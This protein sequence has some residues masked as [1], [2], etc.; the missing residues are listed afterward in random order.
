[1]NSTKSGTIRISAIE[2]SLPESCVNIESYRPRFENFDL[3]VSR[4][5]VTQKHVAGE[6]ETALDLAVNA[7]E[8]LEAREPGTLASLDGIIFITQTPDYLFPGNSNLLMKRLGIEQNILNYDLNQGCAGFVYGAN[9]AQSMIATNQASTVALIC[10]DTYSKII[11][12]DD[13]GTSLLFGDGCAVTIFSEEKGAFKLNGLAVRQLARYADLFMVADG[14]A[15]DSYCS[16]APHI[17]MQGAALLSVLATHAPDFMKK[18][19]EDEGINK[20]DFDLVICHQASRVAL[21]QIGKILGLPPSLMFRNIENF[22]NTTCAS[23]PIALWDAL[24]KPESSAYNK[25]FVFGFGVGF[26]MGA[27]NLERV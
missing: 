24:S 3:A 20:D 22:G 15:R 11:S 18:F 7:F 23:I 1:M 12:P 17:E 25:I 2:I 19:L 13:R 27:M 6:S 16:S 9:L 21:D 4:S 8:K 5:G 26:S 10:S 14:A